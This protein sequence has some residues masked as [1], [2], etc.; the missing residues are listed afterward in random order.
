LGGRSGGD[1]SWKSLGINND[2]FH[3]LYKILKESMKKLLFTKEWP[4]DLQIQRCRVSMTQ[5]NGRASKRSPG[6]VLILSI[7]ILIV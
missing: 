3:T 1:R 4:T 5:G 6:G 2:Q 7:P